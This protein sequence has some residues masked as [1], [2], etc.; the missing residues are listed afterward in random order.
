MLV[1]TQYN[2][3]FVSA[4]GTRKQGPFFGLKIETVF[5]RH[6]NANLGFNA[7]VACPGTAF[8]FLHTCSEICQA[9]C[10]QRFTWR[11]QIRAST[12]RPLTERRAICNRFG[13]RA[14]GHSSLRDRLCIIIP[15]INTARRNSDG[16]RVAWCCKYVQH[17]A[18]RFHTW[19]I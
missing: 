3:L 8:Y 5:R 14:M 16:A 1:L 10:L 15:C 18:V 11:V 9:L 7:A 6:C 17:W 2:Q 19:S 4:I 12:S 13:R